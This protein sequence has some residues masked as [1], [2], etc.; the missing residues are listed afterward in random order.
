MRKR[1][2]PSIFVLFC[3]HVCIFDIEI[4]A[5]FNFIFS[6]LDFFICKLAYSCH[7]L[8][9]LLDCLPFKSILKFFILY[10]INLCLSYTWMIYFKLIIYPLTLLDIVLLC[11]Q[12]I[13]FII[14]FSFDNNFS[15][16]YVTSLSSQLLKTISMVWGRRL[17]LFTN[18]STQI[19]KSVSITH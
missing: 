4:W 17:T 2:Y 8:I 3:L 12:A 5:S 10:D 18:H 7:L 15:I 16:P 19:A 9:R 13:Y 6:Y 11:I 1:K 14:S